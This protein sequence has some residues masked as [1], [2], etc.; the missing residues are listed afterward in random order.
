MIEGND[1]I[2]V[3]KGRYAARR[4]SLDE[5]THAFRDAI[6]GWLKERKIAF[7]LV[8]CRTKT[9]ESFA[10]KASRPDRSYR[11]P[12]DEIKDICGV[13]VI[14]RYRSDVDAVAR[15]LDDEFK[16]VET[17]DK[18]AGL[19]PD[20]LGYASIHKVISLRI[21]DKILGRLWRHGNVRVEVQVRTILEHAWAAIS[22]ELDYKGPESAPPE[23]QRNLL[24]LSGLLEIAD[25][26]FEDLR[27]GYS[28]IRRDT[29]ERLSAGT[30]VTALDAVRLDEFVKSLRVEEVLKAASDAGVRVVRDSGL[31]DLH[32]PGLARMCA[33]LGLDG[34]ASLDETLKRALPQAR[35]F[36]GALVRNLG[37]HG[38]IVFIAD[39]AFL[40]AALIA[41]AHFERLRE[42][43]ADLEEVLG[44]G[45]L[46][47][48]HVASALF[49]A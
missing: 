22:H 15:V 25:E 30:D 14:V 29:A 16:I 12:I 6:E 34:L 18:R 40:V 5:A 39:P 13:R 26:R 42:K 4:Q 48:V 27:K 31:D 11:D 17:E 36:F 47:A 49:R 1:D 8:E 19:R 43:G 24:L 44:R 35:D 45:V 2:D 46:R 33:A 7:H 20:Q 32:T 9:P 21:E 28:E 37:E 10:Q 23:L 38:A 3:W 41:G